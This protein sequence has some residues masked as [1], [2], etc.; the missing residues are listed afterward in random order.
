MNR[1]RKL[2]LQE[3]QQAVRVYNAMAEIFTTEARDG[4]NPILARNRWVEV[5]IIECLEDI[6]D[7][8]VLLEAWRM[9]VKGRNVTGLTWHVTKFQTEYAGLIKKGREEVEF[10]IEVERR[11]ARVKVGAR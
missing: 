10:N 7:E 5:T 1:E 8:R 4:D 6:G 11:R 2:T 3:H 9:W